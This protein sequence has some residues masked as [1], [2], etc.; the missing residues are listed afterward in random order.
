MAERIG[1]GETYNLLS[2]ILDR[3]T[4]Q[5]MDHGGVV[6]D[7]YGDGLAAMWNAPAEQSQHADLAAQAAQAMLGELGPLNEQRDA[8]LGAR[9]R[10]GIG[11]HTGLAQVGN[12]GSRRR[13]KYGPRGHT[14][15]LT[16]R[17]EAATKVVRVACL[18]SATT[19]AAITLPVARRRV[20]RAQLTGLT[21]PVDLYEL[22]EA[23]GDTTWPLRCERYEAALAAWERDRPGECLQ[24]LRQL[25]QEFGREDGPVEWLASKAQDRTSD[26][27]SQFQSVFAVETK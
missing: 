3:L 15:N 5:V 7:Y 6:I 17:I 12:A 1:A 24:L 8:K 22:P 25:Q 23:E 9:L 13:L 2:D 11:L 20:C 21:E 14:V 16:S 19:N 10:L 18:V 4:N 26:S 27:S